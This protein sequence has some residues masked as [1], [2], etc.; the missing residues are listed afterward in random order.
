M[1]YIDLLGAHRRSPQ[2]LPSLKTSW[3]DGAAMT[4]DV[5]SAM[6]D[7]LGFK[8][9][10]AVYGMIETMGATVVSG[11]DDPLSVACENNGRIIG[12]Y[13]IR[14][15]EP[16][17]DVIHADGIVGEILVRGEI[18]MLGYYKR[19]DDTARVIDSDG[20][21]HTRDLGRMSPEGYLQV[22][23]RLNDMFIVGGSNVYPSEVERILQGHTA[24][25]QAVVGVPDSRLGEVGFAFI[26]LE[27]TTSP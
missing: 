23:G 18:V 13:E 9:I 14:I 19:P 24:I 21:F 15:V 10:Q 4:P 16:K 1:H 17:T 12:N 25:R 7:E 11:F 8:R 5:V 6:R 22:T 20:W 26:Q 2:A 3:I 27:K